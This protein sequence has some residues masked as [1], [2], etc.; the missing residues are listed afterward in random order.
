[1]VN[2]PM[3]GNMGTP[4]APPQPQQVNFTT[5]AES[6]GGFNNFLK[7]MPNTT[8][9]APPPPMG[10]SP[11]MPMGNPMGNIDIFNQP[12]SMGMGMM[13]MNQPQMNPMMQPPMQQ[14][15]IGLQPPMMNQPI[16][17]ANQGGIMGTPVQNFYNGG[18]VDD[19]GDFSSVGDDA[20]SVDDGGGYDYSDDDNYETYSS[21]SS[22][23]E[24]NFQVGL[25]NLNTG[26]DAPSVDSMFSNDPQISA[27]INVG[28][29]KSGGFKSGVI[30]GP[31]DNRFSAFRS[32]PFAQ[33]AIGR[34]FAT[35]VNRNVLNEAGDNDL[36][37]S[38][39][40]NTYNTSDD[41]KDRIAEF[42][43][44]TGKGPND[45]LSIND[46]PNI[47]D[48]Q[49]KYEAGIRG[50]PA[51][52]IQQIA[53]TVPM[54]NDNQ[55]ASILDN[56]DLSK[57]ASTV[58]PDPMAT[59]RSPGRM[60]AVFGPETASTFGG[61]TPN[62]VMGISGITSP[63][64][65]GEIPV[66]DNGFIN[67][68][69]SSL[70]NKT[71][72]R[73]EFVNPEDRTKDIFSPSASDFANFQNTRDQLP[74]VDVFENIIDRNFQNN[75]LAGANLPNVASTRS[76]VAQDQAKAIANLVGDRDQTIGEKLQ[77]NI[78]EERGSLEE[79]GRALGP[80]T[81]SDDLA[82]FSANVRGQT[83]TEIS[84]VG[85]D[86]LA[87]D[88]AERAAKGASTVGDDFQTALD[89][90]DA[91]QKE[92]TARDAN[93]RDMDDIDRASAG[94]ASDF[95]TVSTMPE[96]FEE[97]VGRKFDADRMA[98]IERL[99]NRKV[100]QAGTGVGDALNTGSSKGTDPSTGQMISDRL[101]KDLGFS[102]PSP[103][104]TIADFVENITRE[105][106]ANEIAM[107]R[108]MGLGETLFGYD[109]PNLET[110]TM[111]EYMAN[112]QKNVLNE[113]GDSETVSRRLP[114]NQLIRNDSGRVI[115]IRNASGRVVSGYDPDAEIPSEDGDDPI[116]L[117]KK[118]IE[119]A[120]EEEEALDP[121][122]SSLGGQIAEQ[123]A[124]ASP[125]LVES[126]FTSNVGNYDPVG[127]GGTGDL[128]A[129]IARLIGGTNP[130]KA[131]KGGVIGY[132]GGGLISA[133]DNFLASV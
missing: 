46:M 23:N 25:D 13:G 119:K 78:L 38:D 124:V 1:M 93:V 14:P 64:Q 102:I 114:E 121:G 32:V 67:R 28:L 74:N 86:Q 103:L 20:P 49:G 9:M 116:I 131:A 80:T 69:L 98:D 52:Q 59:D 18:G 24:E 70:V 99:Y 127:Y 96:D 43:S 65:T 30:P 128:N 10:L 73:D 89:L 54:N 62:E 122:S 120:K 95:P 110:Q 27:G 7:S 130:K 63:G 72:G 76:T 100:G 4:P 56:L 83:P 81:F 92:L 125:Y 85:D 55:I 109:A 117:R 12:P 15:N 21:P 91:R 60:N 48:I 40:F 133:V 101:K 19:F 132:A 106:M 51:G 111:K 36:T 79:R 118:L 113:A 88:A 50:T 58:E 16:T 77:Q 66:I 34:D 105:N 71:L 5:T 39:Y 35:K 108:P 26:S 37:V 61:L 129:L 11:P 22:F 45:M 123:T 2:G 84:R 112:T 90:V 53:S 6:R 33:R 29:D 126:P 57:T 97:N 44:A 41:N 87:I 75:G 17:M 8:N 42:E 94:R 3:G 31:K 104:L 107:G 68:Q 82:N 115:G 47:M